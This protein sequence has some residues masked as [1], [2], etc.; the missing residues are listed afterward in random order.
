MLA[1]M[2]VWKSFAQKFDIMKR[3]I[4]TSIFACLLILSVFAKAQTNYF[5]EGFETGLPTTKPTTETTATLSSGS[6]AVKGAYRSTSKCDGT[7]GF[8]FIGG[9]NS[10]AITP[11]LSNGVSS[12]TFSNSRASIRTMTFFATTKT[13]LATITESDWVQIGTTTS[14]SAGCAAGLY[15]VN[16]PQSANIV[17]TDIRRV[18][19]VNATGSDNDI[20]GLSIASA[21]AT[22][23][24]DVDVTAFKLPGQVGTETINYAAGT[25]N[26]N[27]ATGTDITNVAPTT[28]SISS[29]ATVSPLANAAQ[30]FNNP[31]N[32]IVTAQD[33][34]TTKTWTVNTTFIL[35]S[36]KEITAFKLSNDQIGNASIN[37]AT[38]QIVVTMPT[39]A[40]LSALTPITF[41]I[42]NL[43]SVNPNITAAQDFSAPVVYTVTAQNGST[44]QWTVSVVTVDPN[45][46]FNTYEAENASFTGKVDAQHAGF[47]GTG[48]IDFLATGDNQITFTVCNQ[49]A[50]VQT[51]KFRYS[52]AKDENRSAALYVNDVFVQTVDF[53][54]TPTF[55][56]WT[57]TFVSVNLNAGVNSIKLVWETTDGPNLDRLDLSGAQCTSY[58]LTVN[59]ANSGTVAV[60]PLRL[61]NKYFSGEQVTLLAEEKPALKLDNWSG[62]LSGTTNPQTLTMN[63]NK[64]VTANFRVI[65]TYRLTTNVTGIGSITLNPAG[66]EYPDGTVVTVTANT[67]LG[68]T[69][70]GWSGDLAGASATQTITVNG[71]KTVTATFTD[72]L[73]INFRQPVGFAS[74]NG[75]GF[76]GPTT[77]GDAVVPGFTNKI[78]YI[79]GPAEFNKLAQTLYNRIRYK[80]MDASPLTI[81]LEEGVYQDVALSPAISVWGNHMLD[82]QEQS[83]LTIIGRKN[84]VFKFGIN[85][86]RSSNIIIRNITFQDYYDDGINIGNTETHHIW[87]DH[88]TVGHPTTLPSD[89]EHPDGGIDIKDGASYVT[90]SWTIYR[91]SWKTGLIGHSDNNAGTDVG[92]LKVTHYANHF[93]NTNSRNPRVRFGE[94]HVLNCLSDGVKLYGIA[95]AIGA[96]VFAENNFYLNTRWGMY[97]DRTLADFRAVFGNNTDDM[98]TS[99]TGN[100]AAFGLKQVGNEYDDSGLPVITGQIN[101]AML[102][103]GGRSVKFDELNAANVFNPS[104]YYSYT[105]LPASVVRVIVPIYAGADKVDWF[106]QALPLDFVAFEA[107]KAGTATNPQVNLT[108]KT[109]REENTEKIEV[110]RKGDAGDFAVINTQPTKNTAGEH[111][112]SFTDRTPL[113]GNNYY[114]LKQYDKDGKT[115]TSEM[116][117]VTILDVT[118]ALNVYPN[119]T[120]GIITIKHS[121]VQVKGSIAVFDTQ[122]QQKMKLPIAKAQLATTL[123]LSSLTSGFY[124]LKVEVDGKNQQIKVIKK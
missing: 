64:T 74:A 30:N 88:C 83:N 7:Y 43:A 66:G 90:I 62:D 38:G 10:Y 1:K 45:L 113:L 4:Q 46:T 117:D 78:I 21:V 107:K 19:I 96:N 47:S 54:R 98:F 77:G 18:R 48:F 102:N 40:S 97:A 41:T 106:P 22:V 76:N 91:N 101:P 65:N 51:A 6:W 5:T 116:R 69:F 103:P 55:T 79:N 119:P 100:K 29:G 53:P 8:R 28:F 58:T 73:N 121:A 3:P 114:Q 20:D 31:V 120:T 32:Y 105:A 86:K 124:L 104:S 93:L 13:D 44:K 42:S 111:S 49:Q 26:I 15:T 112:Y 39:T 2:L 33:G 67:V 89:S 37:S 50:G 68:S 52:F 59:T 84:V 110:L 23:S 87:V 24:S 71:N 95:A 80:Y 57:D 72:N 75:D 94:V 36:E 70:Q 118:E 115:S 9:E 82:I 56:D 34:V 85:V 16:F 25:I 108:W 99:K 60:T 27:I 109:A 92:R 14:T 12:L 63:S 61:N 35:S 11:V 81:V 123:D 17:A 122:G